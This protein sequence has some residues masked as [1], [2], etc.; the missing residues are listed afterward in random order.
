MSAL[1]VA[2]TSGSP[3]LFFTVLSTTTLSSGG[4]NPNGFSTIPIPN[5]SFLLT[6]FLRIVTASPP[7]FRIPLPAGR[8][9]SSSNSGGGSGNGLGTLFE[10]I[11][12]RSISAS[13]VDVVG[14]PGSTTTRI[15]LTLRVSLLLRTIESVV[16]SS[17]I[18][19]VPPTSLLFL[20]VIPSSTPTYTVASSPVSL[21][22]GPGADDVPFP[23]GGL[24]RWRG[25]WSF[26][27]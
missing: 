10:L 25:G 21:G 15:P 7:T 22:G 27:L 12:L 8:S 14:S 17:S 26:L 20:T 11:T 19:I 16:F 23:G 3:A 24:G 6:T 13:S 2:R 5:E 1:R 18:P 4:P 9:W